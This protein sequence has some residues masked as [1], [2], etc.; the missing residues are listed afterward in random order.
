[1]LVTDTLTGR[2]EKALAMQ[3]QRTALIELEDG[4][5]KRNHSCNASEP[6]D[7]DENLLKTGNFPDLNGG[8]SQDNQILIEPTVK[9]NVNPK[10]LQK[11]QDVYMTKD[12]QKIDRITEANSYD[13]S[14]RNNSR[15]NSTVVVSG[16]LPSQP[17]PKIDV[18]QSFQND[19]IK[20]EDEN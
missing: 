9:L 14:S 20:E 12:G 11:L 2:L 13:E 7:E 18:N 8:N 16:S 1:M 5:V 3:L 15:F 4:H 6:S 10:N 19:M 17:S